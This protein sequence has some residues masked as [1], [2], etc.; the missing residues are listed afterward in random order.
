MGHPVCIQG[1]SFD[2][3]SGT[4]QLKPIAIS[5]FNIYSLVNWCASEGVIKIHDRTEF[6]EG[7][8]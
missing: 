2:S 3:A 4:G 5:S 7:S 8:N 1:D 6:C